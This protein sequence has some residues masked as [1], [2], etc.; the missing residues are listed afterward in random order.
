MHLTEQDRII[1]LKKIRKY[2]KLIASFKKK[3]IN[4]FVF[5]VFWFFIGLYNFNRGFEWVNEK[6]S[7]D[8]EKDFKKAVYAPQEERNIHLLGCM[9]KMRDIQE[10][11]FDIKIY[12]LI[13]INLGVFLS[14]MGLTMIAVGILRWREDED[15]ILIRLALKKLL[16][17]PDT[18]PPELPR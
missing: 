8:L 15:Y 16:E 3:R 6:K 9:L 11:R 18:Q 13:M 1:A 17:E 5:A 7:Y 14:L 12:G 10:A 2:D 4:L